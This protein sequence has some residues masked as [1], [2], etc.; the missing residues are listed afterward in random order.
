MN[1]LLTM[2]GG[3][4]LV[5]LSACA[6][7][8]TESSASAAEAARQVTEAIGRNDR[9]RLEQLAV[10]ETE[11]REQVW[12]ELP[13]ARPERNLT[14]E[15][16]WTDLHQKSQASLHDTL[17]K[18]AGRGYAFVDVRFQG[19]VSRYAGYEVHREAVVRLRRP[20]GTETEERLFGSMIQKDDRWK[21]FSY[22]VD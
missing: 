21:I 17:R 12:P 18:H 16:V 14:A 6:Q 13:A 4:V 15:Y 22:V 9:G 10:N 7:P 1:Y 20:D 8:L 11:F 5:G 2:L 3:L 19:P